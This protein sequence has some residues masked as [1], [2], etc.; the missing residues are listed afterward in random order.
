MRVCLA[1]QTLS[2]SVAAGILTYVSLNALPA[3]A[4]HTAEFVEN[5]DALFD[6]FNVK[7]ITRLNK[8]KTFQQRF[9]RFK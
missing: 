9:D 5:I 7:T 3:E 1:A 2:H 6:I 8:H 4:A